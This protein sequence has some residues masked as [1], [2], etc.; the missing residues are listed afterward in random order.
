MQSEAEA[1]LYEILMVRS[2]STGREGKGPGK[3]DS[4]VLS[5]PPYFLKELVYIGSSQ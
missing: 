3:K 1:H 2:T 4:W 5:F